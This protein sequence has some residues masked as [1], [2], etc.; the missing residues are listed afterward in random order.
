MSYGITPGGRLLRG[1]VAGEKRVL[2]EF[3]KSG[4]CRR[5]D[6]RH[7]CTAATDTRA[8]PAARRPRRPPAPLDKIRRNAMR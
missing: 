8:R 1:R 5:G 7:F 3:L 4:P 2:R 6:G